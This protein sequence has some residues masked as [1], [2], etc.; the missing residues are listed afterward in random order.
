MLGKT[1]SSKFWL[2]QQNQLLAALFAGEAVLLSI[3]KET[4]KQPDTRVSI[5]N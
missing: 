2:I 4:S 3:A 1:F 5:A